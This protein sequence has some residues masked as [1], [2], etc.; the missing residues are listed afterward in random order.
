HDGLTQQFFKAFFIRFKCH[1]SVYKYA[2]IGPDLVYILHFVMLN[3]HFHT[4]LA[5]GRHTYYIADVPFFGMLYNFIQ[6]LVPVAYGSN[7]SAGFVKGLKPERSF[8]GQDAT[9][10]ACIPAGAAFLQIGC[11]SQHQETTR[12]RF[13]IGFLIAEYAD[14]LA[15]IIDLIAAKQVAGNRNILAGRFRST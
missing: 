10:V 14:E 5:P 15:D 3:D 11:A 8:L 6:L 12:E 9:E 13:L 7:S 1:A 4:H 2:E